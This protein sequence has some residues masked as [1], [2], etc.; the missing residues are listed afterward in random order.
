MYKN[1]K[2]D[3]KTVDTDKY[4]KWLKSSPSINLDKHI[5][6]KDDKITK[7]LESIIEKSYEMEFID[8]KPDIKSLSGKLLGLNQII[9]DYYLL[10]INN[11][12]NE[13]IKNV[14]KKYRYRGRTILNEKEIDKILEHSTHFVYIISN[15][16][17]LNRILHQVYDQLKLDPHLDNGIFKHSPV[18]IRVKPEKMK[19]GSKLVK[20]LDKGLNKVKK[21]D[22]TLN[23]GIDKVNKINDKI[24]ST[25]DNLQSFKPENFDQWV[26][27]QAKRFDDAIINKEVVIKPW[28]WFF[29]GVD[30]LERRHP[31]LTYPFDLVNSVLQGTDSILDIVSK[32]VSLLGGFGGDGIWSILSAITS[33]VGLIPFAGSVSSAIGIAVDVLDPF[34]S[35][36]SGGLSDAFGDLID[37]F[38]GILSFIFNLSRK[39]WGL[40]IWA[41]LDVLDMFGVDASDTFDGML[42]NINNINRYLYTINERFSE[43]LELSDSGDVLIELIQQ[44]IQII[45]PVLDVIPFEQI[46]TLF[47]DYLSNSGAVINDTIVLYSDL[48]KLF[49]PYYIMM[50]AME[51][52]N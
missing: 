39:N 42:T 30:A 1:V 49:P 15:I 47:F 41:F 20:T 34:I 7:T 28:E 43:I 25:L 21:I 45:K 32:I 19:G 46:Q 33:G 29:F 2:I 11:V 38:G 12:D 18:V 52:K 16:G 9:N 17:N 51:N 4:I 48:M 3:G 26:K 50:K 6:L 24:N 5:N 36:L 40:A 14:F 10:L 44:Q 27:Q 23:K 35:T 8:E 31:I 37:G 13:T 22:D